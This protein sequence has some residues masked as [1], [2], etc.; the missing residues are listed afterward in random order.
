M[1]ESGVLIAWARL[2]TWGA[3]ALDDLAIGIDQRV[4]L[5][6]ERRDLDREFALEPLCPPGANVGDRLRD[7]LERREAEADLEHRGQEQH[8]A[9]RGEGAAEVI[10]EAARLVENLAVV[11][12]DADQIFAVGAEI[13]RPFHHPQVLPLGTIDI[14]EPDAGGGELGTVLLQLRQLLVP[15]RAR[16]AHLRLFGVGARD[17][18]I[19]AGQRQLEQGL[20]ERLELAVRGLVRG[21]D[22]RDQRAEIEIEPAVE[23][24]FGRVLVDRRQHHAGDGQ[25]HHEP[26][27][28]RQEQ[29]VGKR[30]SGHRNDPG[31]RRMAGRRTS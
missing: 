21:R 5:A 18:P 22:L 31:R 19:P 20:A 28:R 9:E 25:D 24:A 10:V 11:A 17:L 30:A 7:A 6:R 4:C 16:G 12:G 8:D 29:A 23:G 1:T 14:A 13:D 26:R 15:E 3:R 27:R 2:P